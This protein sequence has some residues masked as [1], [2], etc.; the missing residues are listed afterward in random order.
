MRR[1]LL[2]PFT[3]LLSEWEW[4]VALLQEVP[5]WW[6]AAL[7]EA[8]G[9][10]ARWVLTSRNF[11]LALRR[12]ISVRDPEILKANGGGCNA[13]LVRGP[14]AE[15]RVARLTWW[16]ERR[17][18]HGVRLPD[19]TWVVNL[20]A[21]THREEWAARDVGRAARAWPVEEPLLFGGD[22]NLRRPAVDGMTWLGG[23]HVDHFFARGLAGAGFEVLDRGE[24]SD[25][26]PIR[27]SF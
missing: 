7:G 12:A 2:G 6:P 24:L 20:H 22:L 19:G 4:D 5:P 15:H 26:P 10:S 11:G 13:I 8:C 18:A 27:V 14:V 16:P 3:E 17:W 21:S 23:N 1:S 9:A 25:H